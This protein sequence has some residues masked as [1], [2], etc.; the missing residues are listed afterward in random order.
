MAH[1][2]R[3]SREEKSRRG[4]GRG[5]CGSHFIKPP[6][7]RQGCSFRSVCQESEP[8]EKSHVF[9]YNHKL[10]HHY[11][12]IESQIQMVALHFCILQS[13]QTASSLSHPPFSSLHFSSF[14]TPSVFMIS[15][16]CAA[17]Q[18][19]IDITEHFIGMFVCVCVCV[20]LLTR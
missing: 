12:V 2:L 8:T 1:R 19:A 18:H 13:G 9:K 11:N 5:S 15:L 16:P 20:S 10:H 17:Q 6:G 3:E 14:I 4:R 7:N